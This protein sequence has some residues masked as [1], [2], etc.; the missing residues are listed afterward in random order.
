MERCIICNSL[1]GENNT[2]GIGF[3]C[4]NNIVKPAIQA[5]FRDVKGLDLWVAKANKLKNEYLTTFSGVKFRSDFKRSFYE[6]M[7]KSERVSKKQFEIMERELAYK[8]IRIDMN[9]EVFRPMWNSFKYTDHEDIYSKHL[10]SFKINY[11]NKNKA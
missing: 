7:S 1:L 5:T 4:I 10:E 11:F 6:S 9:I 8:G 3:G 2:T